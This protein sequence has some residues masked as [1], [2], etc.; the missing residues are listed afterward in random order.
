MSTYLPT[1]LLQARAVW[2]ALAERP[3]LPAPLHTYELSAEASQSG[4]GEIR[5]RA[6]ETITTV[7]PT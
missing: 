5:L 3:Y 1:Y 2:R 6:T 4:G 7:N